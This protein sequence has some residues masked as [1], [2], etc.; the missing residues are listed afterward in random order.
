MRKGISRLERL[1]REIEAFDATILTKRW[2]P[3]QAALEATIKG[4]LTSVFGHETVEYR[5][6][7]RATALDHGLNIM[8]INGIPRDNSHEA[9][10]Y[11]GEGKV[12]AVQILRSAIK[13]L[14]D[15][16]GDA[17]E[18]TPASVPARA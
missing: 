4:T 8:S 11:V 9:R 1:I 17:A 12:A 6:Y 18:S 15:E 7:A 5:R 14:Q 13:W 16:V 10:Q 3:E 2:S